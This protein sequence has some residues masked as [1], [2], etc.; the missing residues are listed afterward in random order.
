MDYQAV[1]CAQCRLFVPDQ[2]GSGLGIGQCQAFE[3]YKQ[4]GVSVYALDK[5]FRLL[6]NKNFLGR[7]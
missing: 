2:V 7:E 3:E 5:A 4:K 1:H 6:G